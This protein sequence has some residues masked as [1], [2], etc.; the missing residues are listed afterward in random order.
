MSDAPLS[1]LT[2][3]AEALRDH[4]VSAVDIVEEA[5]Q[6]HEDRDDL[7]GAYKLFDADGARTAAARADEM[8]R[9]SVPAP[10]L[11]GIP[12][13][14]KDLYGVDRLPTFAGTP[15]QLPDR[16][17]TDAWLVARMRAQGAVFM[18]KTHTVEL[19]Y[20]AVGINP[21]WTTP[22]NPWDAREHRIPGGSS[23][24]A[25][26][27]L[28][29]GSAMVALGTDTGGSIRIPASMTGVVG[30]KTTKGRLPTDGVV[31]LSHTLDTVGAL[32]RSVEDSVYFFGAVDPAW[33]DPDAL[34]RQLS[35]R[36]A[37]EMRVAVPKCG[38]WS[39]CQDDIAGVLG[40]AL[41]ELD[42][43]DWSRADVDG[44]LL[45]QA[46]DLYMTGG[47]AGVECLAFL[48]RDLPGWLG[49]LHPIVGERIAAAAAHSQ[50]AYRQALTRREE[51]AH[52]A[53]AL[54]DQ[55]DVLALPT[56]I[57]TPPAVGA[58]DDRARYME[59]NAAALRPTCA[60][61][62]LGLCAVTLPVGLDDA[63]MPVGLQLVGPE[64][65]DEVVLAAALAAERVFGTGAERLGEPP[66]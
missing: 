40:G 25:G 18:G 27:S 44:G 56:A 62:I 16:W 10:P 58:L 6:R 9:G 50:D 31:P 39:A 30:H 28:H 54:F 14:V 4:R 19:A 46:V 41:E 49:I 59:T 20:G 66:R 3:A 29:E 42:R 24:G 32:T 63:G 15:R 34:L 43:G 7:H 12:V 47:I 11:C 23:A 21:N 33:G 1:S 60:V 64:G 52:A 45:D 55:A 35:A 53:A 2:S 8:L 13:S 57:V 38:I 5:I 26:V 51:M 61:S 37:A 17:S 36:G 65:H 22:R 48:E